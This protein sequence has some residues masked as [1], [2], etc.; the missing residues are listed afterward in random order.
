MKLNKKTNG[1]GRITSFTI[2]IAKSEA[3]LLDWE[4]GEILEKK[5]NKSKKILIIKQKEE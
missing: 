5:I 1:Q 3:A 4:C 2:N